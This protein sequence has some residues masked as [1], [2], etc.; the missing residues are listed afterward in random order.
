MLQ[1]GVRRMQQGMPAIVRRAATTSRA[2]TEEE[3]RG[4]VS[5][6]CACAIMRHAQGLCEQRVV[7]SSVARGVRFPPTNHTR[8]FFFPQL[9]QHDYLARIL[10]ARVY[11]VAIESPLQ[12]APYMSRA[13]KNT[14][15]LKVCVMASFTAA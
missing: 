8:S 9:T 14:V 15:L 6:S 4:Q 10:N 7:G 2:C 12:A 11:E 13:I 3:L 5:Q 1:G